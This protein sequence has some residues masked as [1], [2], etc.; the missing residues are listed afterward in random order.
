MANCG[1]LVGFGDKPIVLKKNTD[2]S[3]GRS[4]VN[5]YPIRD[6]LLSRCHIQ[7]DVTENGDV[8][9]SDLNSSNHT[10]LNGRPLIPHMAEKLQEGDTI[11]MGS[12]TMTYQMKYGERKKVIGEKFKTS[13]R[14]SIDIKS[15]AG[16]MNKKAVQPAPARKNMAWTDLMPKDEIQSNVPCPETVVVDDGDNKRTFDI[17]AWFVLPKQE[18][19]EIL[20]QKKAT[21]LAKG[22][23]LPF[24]EAL[25]ELRKFRNSTLA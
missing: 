5:D 12:Q 19:I 11:R 13:S 22:K 24:F 23:E 4:M 8:M 3:F 20:Q 7:I 18:R 1:Y 10:F 2:L 17:K 15:V 14:F 6:T 25:V 21:F 9:V 16:L